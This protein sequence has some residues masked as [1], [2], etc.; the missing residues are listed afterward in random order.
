[1]LT[2][3]AWRLFLVA[4]VVA[5][6]PCPL[7]AQSGGR[8]ALVIGNS[9][10]PKAPLPS[11]AADAERVGVALTK[12]GYAVTL[13]QNMTRRGLEQALSVF[14]QKL[15]P[16]GT[17]LIYYAG[18]GV[19]VDGVNVLLP[20][21]AAPAD[22][23]QVLEQGMPLDPILDRLVVAR[24]AVSLVV[25]DAGYRFPL[26]KGQ[27]VGLAALPVPDDVAVLF[28]APANTAP[29]S[30]A[31]G[32]RLA[33]ELAR[34]VQQPGL[35]APALVDA[36]RTASAPA[37]GVKAWFAKP[38]AAGPVVSGPAGAAAVA[39]AAPTAPAPAE[40][41][42]SATTTA[43]P[44]GEPVRDCP[45]CP[46]L[47]LVKPGSFQMGA[48]DGMDF[49]KPVHAVTI[50]R[51]FYLGVR[52]V[53]FA[54]WDA[55]ADAGG[56]QARPSD[57]GAGRGDRPVTDVSWPD[58]KEYVAWLSGQTG[59]TYRLPSEAEWEYAARAGTGTAYPWGAGPDKDKANC[60]GCT[61]EP[62]KHAVASGRFP[63]NAWGLLDMAGNAAEWVEDC[64][65]DSYKGAPSDGSAR[66]QKDC[67]EHVL[68]GGSFN[69]DPR[70][71]RSAARFKYDTDVRYFTNGLRVA[72]DP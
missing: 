70:Y 67:R 69:N 10:Y 4:I 42:R 6:V 30:S 39:S 27:A 43:S 62:I 29:A 40:S 46:E 65:V 54:E 57:R 16:G 23:A 55:C 5:L 36:L 1:M 71:L 9:N 2:P 38:K 7:M 63:P 25:L 47:V 31:Q 21:D 44:P 37:G 35:T 14:T 28:A 26:G 32:S 8:F 58:A 72:R 15:A 45:T 22:P 19:Q 52:E 20:I 53:T 17:A 34:L 51:P 64:W 48:N 56:C 61:A 60:I 68:R 12:A 59:K 49:E 13:G 3:S 66:V 33:A 24:Q 50:A 11:A 41:S 18:H